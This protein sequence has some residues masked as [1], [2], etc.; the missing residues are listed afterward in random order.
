MRSS[1]R[2]SRPIRPRAPPFR[3]RWPRRKCWWR[4]RPLP[5]SGNERAVPA[6]TALPAI[7]RQTL[8]M[9]SVAAGVS[10]FTIQDVIVKTLS[11]VYPVH[12]IVVIRSLVA[13][14]ILLWATYAEQHG[15]VKMHRGL[16]HAAR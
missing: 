13:F 16:L 4:S 3:Q 11:S 8:G 9:I 7:S 12:Q 5:I 2:R 15:H 1:P 6:L 10:V 14:P